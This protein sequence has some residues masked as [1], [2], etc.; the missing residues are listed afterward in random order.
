MKIKWKVN[1]CSFDS[2]ITE[3]IMEMIISNE[4]DEFLWK[5][6]RK[7]ILFQ[8]FSKDVH[9]ISENIPYKILDMLNE[10]LK[11]FSK[12]IIN[13]TIL[14]IDDTMHF[15]SM[16]KE[17][18]RLSE[19]KKLLF[20]YVNHCHHELSMDK[21]FKSNCIEQIRMKCE[22]RYNRKQS[23]VDC[24]KFDKIVEKFDSFLTEWETSRL[25]HINLLTAQI[26]D[27]KF[28]ETIIEG[29]RMVERKENDEELLRNY[30]QSR[31]INMTNLRNQIEC[32]WRKYI[33]QYYSKY[34]DNKKIMGFLCELNKRKKNYKSKISSVEEI[35]QIIDEQFDNFIN[36]NY[37]SDTR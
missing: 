22:E 34:A 21:C 16:R 12:S 30:E 10:N 27:E 6:C 33:N 23:N 4:S 32:E 15:E 19:G 11:N 3:E 35:H 5:I 37:N 28:I 7:Y 20:L 1:Y 18:L 25:L 36:S 14:I 8:L 24:R 26:N 31:Q 17:L 2:L 13:S 9:H 29:G